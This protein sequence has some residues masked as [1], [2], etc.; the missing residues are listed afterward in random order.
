MSG[1]LPQDDMQ[2]DTMCI[3]TAIR[4]SPRR[5]YRTLIRLACVHMLKR[6]EADTTAEHGV[7]R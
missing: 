2:E 5:E 3:R 4:M 1:L 7:T 6:V